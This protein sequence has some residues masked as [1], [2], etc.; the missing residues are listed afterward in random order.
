MNKLTSILWTRRNLTIIVHLLLISGYIALLYMASAADMQAGYFEP[1]TDALVR[2]AAMQPL[3][4][5]YLWLA[6]CIPGVA[7]LFGKTKVWLFGL[8]PPG[9]CL[10]LHAS[11]PNSWYIS[12][13]FALGFPIYFVL[14][15]TG[16]GRM[17]HYPASR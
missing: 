6:L 12:I 16:W 2:H 5:T 11:Y 13:V 4:Y 10:V 1:T 15:L 9:L 8:L 14:L 17:P 3:I 7:L